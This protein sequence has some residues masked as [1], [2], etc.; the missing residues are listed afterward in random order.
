[1]CGEQFSELTTEVNPPRHSRDRP[2]PIRDA[3]ALAPLAGPTQL[4]R[5]SLGGCIPTPCPHPCTPSLPLPAHTYIYIRM[6]PTRARTHPS[7]SSEGLFVMAMPI[8]S[9]AGA[10]AY[11]TALAP[12]RVLALCHAPAL[13]QSVRAGWRSRESKLTVSVRSPAS[14]LPSASRLTLPWLVS[15]SVAKNMRQTS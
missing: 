8:A 10:T 13:A 11:A 5:R 14:T 7:L 1:M 2:R 15:C 3:I 4:P 6:T 9:R 12:C